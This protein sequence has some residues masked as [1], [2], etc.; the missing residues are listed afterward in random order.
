MYCKRKLTKSTQRR[1]KQRRMY[2]K[3]RYMYMYSVQHKETK[4]TLLLALVLHV[5]YQNSQKLLLINMIS[6]HMTVT[7]A[8]KEAGSRV[9]LGSLFLQT[10]M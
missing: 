9:K 6:S 2:S 4:N 8:G 10:Y 7:L 1:E 3:C 5:R